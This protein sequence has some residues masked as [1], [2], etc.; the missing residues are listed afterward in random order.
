MEYFSYIASLEL[1]SIVGLIDYPWVEI[2]R[3]NFNIIEIEENEEEGIER[4]LTILAICRLSFVLSHSVDDI[5]FADIVLAFY[6]S[7]Q[8]VLLALEV[9]ANLHNLAAINIVEIDED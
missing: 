2:E 8:V 7:D 1:N 5:D 4:F 9:I 6:I 3:I